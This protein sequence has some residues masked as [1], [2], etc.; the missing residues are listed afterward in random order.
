MGPASRHSDIASRSF[1]FD[2]QPPITPT[3]GGRLDATLANVPHGLC[4]FDAERRLVL[5]N[6]R[7]GEMYRLPPDLLVPGTPLER[8]IAYRQQIGNAPV[9]FPGYATHEGIQFKQE[10][11]SLFQFK[12][13]D[14][15]TIRVNH[16]KLDDGGYVATHEDITD[17]VRSEDRFRSIF[18]AV[19]EGIFII[20]AADGTFIEVNQPGCIMLGYSASE[21]NGRDIEVLSSGIAPYARDEMASWIK[22][23]AATGQPQRF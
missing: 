8:I 1:D 23:A 17:A 3:D 4:M 11:N 10:G 2:R 7:Y 20:D 14:G 21:L 19:S 6:S 5:S 22:R 13:Q 9:D 16:L 15:R 12:L 18:D